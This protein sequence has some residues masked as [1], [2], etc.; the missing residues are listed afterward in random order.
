MLDPYNTN[1]SES[2]R[3]DLG[4]LIVYL[5]PITSPLAVVGNF[6]AVSWSGELNYFKKTLNLQDSRRAFYPSLP[7]PFEVP[8]DHIFFSKIFNCVDFH[9]LR[10]LNGIHLGLFASFQLSDDKFNLNKPQSQ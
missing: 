7:N 3:Y 8:K 10:D 6:N 1:Q 5:R 4:R 9:E 2:Y